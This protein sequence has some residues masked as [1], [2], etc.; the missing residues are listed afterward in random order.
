MKN[1]FIPSVL[2]LSLTVLLVGFFGSAAL[3]QN[4]VL[5]FSKTAGYR[6][7][8]IEAGKAALQKMGAEKGFTVDTTENATAFREENLKR[9]HCVIWLSTTG[10]VLNDSQQNAFE[11]YMQAGG[12]YLGIHAASDTEYD[13]PWYGKLVG[14]WFDNHPSKPS[15]V[16]QG[17]FHIADTKNPLTSFLPEPWVRTD[18]FYAYKQMNPAVKVLITIDEKSYSG[19]TMGDNHPMAWYH[20]YDGGRAFYTNMGHTPETFSEPLVLQHVWAGLQWAMGTQPLDYTKAHTAVFPE[21]NRFS[22]VILEEKLDEPMELALL[23]GKKILFIQRKGEVKLFDPALGKS[24]TIANIPVST[25]YLPDSTGKRAEAED[26]LL[27][28]TLDPGFEKNHWVYLYYSPAGDEAKNILTRYEMRN[29]V[30]LPESKKVLLE[31]PVQRDQCCHTAGSMGWDKAGNLF[32]STGDNSSPRADPYAPID[33][34]PGRT[35]W[36]AQRSSGNTNDLRG[37]IIRIHPE[38]NGTYTIPEGN[39]FPKGLAKTR[40]EIYTM[41]HRNPFR[42]TVDQKTGFVYWGEVGPDAN[43]PDEKRGPE[44]YDEVGQARGPGNFGWPYFTA[45]KA[46]LDYD[47]ATQKTGAAYSFEKPLNQSPNNTGLTELPPAKPAFVW[48]SYGESKQFPLVGSGGRNAMAGPVFHREDFKNALRPWPAY[49]DGKFIIYDWMRGWMMAVTM[50]EAGDYVSMEPIMPSY[51]FSN[52]MDMEFA[53]DGDLYM[54]EYGTG[55]FQ[56]NDDARL[57]RLEYNGG[58]RKPTVKIKADKTAGQVPLTVQLAADAQDYDGDKIMY[59]WVVTPKKGGAKQVFRTEKT[60]VT[61]KKPGVYVATL[62]VS[63]GKGGTTVETREIV[64]GNEPPVLDFDLSNS[65]QT[66]FFPGQKINYEVRVQDKEDGSLAKGDIDPAQIALNIDYLPEGYDKI[67]IAQGHRFADGNARFAQAQK[68]MEKTDCKACH[69][70]AEKSVGPSFRAVALKYKGQEDAVE[71]LSGRVINGSSGVWGQVAMA[72]HPSL[73]KADAASLIRFILNHDDEKAHPAPLPVKGEYQT[74]IPADDKGLGAYILRA[75][76][77]DQ[78]A[79]GLPALSSE[80][81]YVLRSPTFEVDAFEQLKGV[82]KMSFDL[83]KLAI[84]S[85]AGAY[86]GL[87]GIDLRGIKQVRVTAS[88]PKQYNFAGGKVELHLDKPDGPLASNIVQIMPSDADITVPPTLD[89]VLLPGMQG[90]HDVFIV[91]KIDTTGGAQTMMTVLGIQFMD[92]SMVAQAANAP[93]TTASLADYAGK[94]KFTGLPFEY[95]EIVPENGKLVAITPDDRGPLSPV[96]TDRFDAGGKAIIEFI[97]LDGKV[98]GMNL[99]P[100]GMTFNGVRQ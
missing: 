64:A 39:L 61:F 90:V 45:D 51:K 98:V 7:S 99:M 97:R 88:A 49:Y 9:Y 53:K 75:S 3:A 74:D 19:G 47:Y 95:I 80:K 27:G 1:Y 55:W 62:T 15:N 50:N 5:V 66:F 87:S 56:G 22:K 12:G 93:A 94:Y 4:R 29:D 68:I 10:N 37:K 42:I 76:Y 32:L 77:Q 28:L 35:P 6:H 16:Q 48:Y 17:T 23:P 89:L 34:R 54:L 31:I 83:R 40:P 72:A 85:G 78:G 41:G 24:S 79:V 60:P 25:K 21:E 91:C 8:S 71:L 52:P 82:Q 92:A 69:K 86:I 20:E 73:S 63:D 65:N 38:A 81:V 36:D 30:L 96:G 11:R 57:V 46:Y 70:T 26:G 59:N 33:E 14:G 44:G 100:P 67:A 84:V 18:E 58:N 13:W 2:Y 43:K